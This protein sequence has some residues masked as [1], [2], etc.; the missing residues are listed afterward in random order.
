LIRRSTDHGSF[1]VNFLSYLQIRLLWCILWCYQLNDGSLANR[2]TSNIRNGAR[3]VLSCLLSRK[4]V[5]Q[6]AFC[7]FC[8]CACYQ[9]GRSSTMAQARG[10][11]IFTM[12]NAHLYSSPDERQQGV[13]PIALLLHTNVHT[14]QGGGFRALQHVSSST[15]A[16]ISQQMR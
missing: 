5:R 16:C 1:S 9:R 7:I 11:L 3:I 2:A 10:K 13:F 14:S 8:L 12:S 15:L 4:K 6:A